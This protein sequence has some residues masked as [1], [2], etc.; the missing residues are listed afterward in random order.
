[1]DY[2]FLGKIE[3]ELRAREEYII[4][5]IA[6]LDMVTVTILAEVGQEQPLLDWMMD[7]TNGQVKMEAGEME[8][9]EFSV[10]PKDT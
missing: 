3:N 4:R 1:M 2:T 8:Y 9:V 10:E 6:Y 7:A 5:D